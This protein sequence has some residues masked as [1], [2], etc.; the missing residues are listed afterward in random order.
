[1]GKFAAASFNVAGLLA[2]LFFAAESSDLSAAPETE[3]DRRFV[4]PTQA[5][6]LDHTVQEQFGPAPES[7]S[8]ESVGGSPNTS[9]VPPFLRRR[10]ALRPRLVLPRQVRVPLSPVRRAI[11]LPK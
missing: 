7:I 5:V 1:M 3:T 8:A 6:R 11:G 10:L 2:A 9:F 4:L